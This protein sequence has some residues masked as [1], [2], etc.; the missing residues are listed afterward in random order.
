MAIKR[1][2]TRLIVNTSAQYARTVINLILSLYSTRLILNALGV[3]DYGVYTL[4]AGVVSMLS[5]MTNAMVTTTQRYL[6]YHQ[7][8]SNLFTLQRLF[9]NSVIMHFIFSFLVLAI[10]EI[11]GLFLFNGF[12]NIIPERIPAAKVVYQCAIFMILTS[13]MTAPFQALLISH[14][15]IVYISVVQVLDG[16]VKVGIATALTIWGSDKLILYGYL[17]LI[18][19]LLNLLA[20]SIYDFKKYKEC[21]IP[22]IKYFDKAYLKSMGSFVGWQLYSTGCIIGRTQGTAIVLNKFFGTV[23]NAS[24]GIALQV[25]GAMNFIS[26]SLFLAINPQII[27]AEGAGNREKMFQLAE[28][29]SKFGFLLLAVLVVPVFFY[30]EPLLQIWLGR[31]PEWS[32]LFCRVIIITALIDQMTLGLATANAAI[33]DIK[34]YS[35]VINSIK[36]ITV[37]FLIVLLILK[38]SLQISIWIYAVM[39]MICAICRI[40]YLHRTGGLNIHEFISKVIFKLPIPLI[41]ISGIYYSITFWNPP[42]WAF[43]GMSVIALFIY[44]LIIYYMSLEDNEKLLIKKFLYKIGLIRTSR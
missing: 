16:V 37:A 24:F 36:I 8:K 4:I 20:Y 42:F 27:K 9:S 19:Y 44:F 25:S 17:M 5:F 35:L 10:L 21:V 15:N 12:L 2:S 11:I 7:T 32:I 31:V 33:G 14:E 38:V 13:F 23:V 39:E 41:I 6:S 3:A 26:S 28:T 18:I 22:K 34:N 30:I 43:L 40:P 29:A 1:N